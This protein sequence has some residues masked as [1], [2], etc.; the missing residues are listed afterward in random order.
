MAPSRLYTRLLLALALPLL[1]AAVGAWALA[2]R[3]LEQTWHERVRHEL[4]AVTRLLSDGGLPL[5]PALLE[6]LGA[7]Q[8]ADLAL[9]DDQGRVLQSTFAASRP[10]LEAA[11]REAAQS[12]TRSR[13]SILPIGGERRLIVLEPVSHPGEPRVRAV[14]GAASLADAQRAAAESARRIGVAV[15]VS[16]LLL[17]ALG[18]W[19]MR[20]IT[21]PLEQ[22]AAMAERIA[23]GDRKVRLRLARRDE[24]G[25]LA[26]AIDGMADRLEQYE[27]QLATRARVTA[28]GEIAS[29]AAHEIR[30][31]L[32]GIK[33]HLQLLQERVGADDRV[34]IEN[35]LAEVRRLELVVDATL[36]VGRERPLACA[37]ADLGALVT[38]VAGLM[39][40]ALAHRGIA[41]ELH[42][43]ELPRLSVDATRIKQVLLN[44]LVNA[45]DAQPSGGRVQLALEHDPGRARA[46]LVVE[47]AGPGIPPAQRT[48]VFDGSASAKPLGL[49]LGLSL[50]REIV[51]QHGGE[52]RAE[53]SP[54]LGG[55]RLVAELPLTVVPAGAS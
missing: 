49:G 13:E 35:L 32:T 41:L 55:A 2:Q 21:A 39:E 15:L 24:I 31:P 54:A 26:R 20:G 46:R 16:G 22:V 3:F 25:A 42:L 27:A 50:S 5:T 34:R 36:A 48:R 40:P 1:L 43:E 37:P 53:S 10:E 4:T 8:R 23:A 28:L 44:L 38:E 12:A 52:L 18:H 17:A 11:L 45:A 47:D 30:N 51:Q 6:R 19:L 9:L 7:L 29:R 14:I 33:M